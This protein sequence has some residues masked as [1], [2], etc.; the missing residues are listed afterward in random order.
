MIIEPVHLASTQDPISKGIV[1]FVLL[2]LFA[3]LTLEKAHR[4]LIAM[5]AVSLIWLVTYLTPYHLISFED[6]A[7]AL[8]LNV[9]LLLASMMALVA[10]LKSTGAFD[11][12]IARLLRGE[13]AT[14]T[15]ILM[16]LA[17]FTA[18]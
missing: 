8:D 14:P 9:L 5:T 4:V 13:G 17:W 16:P 11:W 2:G 10:V 7:K 3:L 1:A 15:R 12:A 18:V 6:S